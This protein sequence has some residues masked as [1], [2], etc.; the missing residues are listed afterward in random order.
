MEIAE[1]NFEERS[2]VEANVLGAMLEDPAYLNIMEAHKAATVS[3][4]ERLA[5]IARSAAQ[6]LIVQ[7]M[8][9]I[10]SPFLSGVQVGNLDRISRPEIYSTR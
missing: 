9:P 3:G 10:K 8:N 5:F 1:N 4:N 7:A 2:L 6:H